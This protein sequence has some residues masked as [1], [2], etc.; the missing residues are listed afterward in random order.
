VNVVAVADLEHP[1][2][3]ALEA[4][5]DVLGKRKRGVAV[6]GDVIVVVDDGELAE[7]KMAGKRRRLA[8]HTLHQVAVAGKDPGP[9]FHHRVLRTVEMRPQEA[10]GDGHTYGVPESLPQRSGCGLDARRVAPFGMSRRPGAPLPEVPNV[11]EGE[12]VAAQVKQRVEQHGGVAA[13][14]HEAVAVGPSRVAWIMAEEPAPE[15]VSGG[16]QGHGGAGMAGLGLLDGVHGECADRVDAAPDQ[17]GLQIVFTIGGQRAVRARD[18][19]TGALGVQEGLRGGCRGKI[20][21]EDGKVGK[22]G[23]DGKVC[24]KD[25]RQFGL[26]P[27]SCST[28]YHTVPSFPSFPAYRATLPAPFLAPTE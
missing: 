24:S 27:G 6:D 10:L 14:E 22:D 23:N 25:E 1:P 20:I 4:A 15:D 2:A 12:I 28:F 19:N 9:V 8:R 18:A 21:E 17:R 5:R 11:F 7:P 3:V 16:S 13:G 26:S